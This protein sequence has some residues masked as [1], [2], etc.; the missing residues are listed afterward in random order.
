MPLLGLFR[1]FPDEPFIRI[2]RPI[3]NL[4]K[5][6]TRLDDVNKACPNPVLTISKNR[7]R[8]SG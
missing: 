3:I 6:N 1:A 7:M 8:E 5:A 4:L 2:C